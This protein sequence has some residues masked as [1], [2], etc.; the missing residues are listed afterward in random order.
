MKRPEPVTPATP[1]RDTQPVEAPPRRGRVV[2][3]SPPIPERS[4]G[5]IVRGLEP[6]DPATVG[7]L[8]EEP[9]PVDVHME[10]GPRVET[11]VPDDGVNVPA[12]GSGYDSL[13][14]DTEHNVAAAYANYLHIE[15]V[16]NRGYH[17]CFSVT[18]TPGTQKVHMGKMAQHLCGH[19]Y[20]LA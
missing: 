6:F 10:E 8:A 7:D 5:L 2:T 9:Q 19:W 4:N 11:P 12:Y 17:P 15:S 14:D 1:A 18:S 13:H 3:L 20:N 16:S